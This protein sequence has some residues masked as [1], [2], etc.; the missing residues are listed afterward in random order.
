MY[1]FI[2]ISIGCLLSFSSFAFHPDPNPE[3]SIPSSSFCTSF[4]EIF[5][6]DMTISPVFGGF[7]GGSMS[8]GGA[9]VTGKIHTIRVGHKNTT[10]GKNDA[11]IDSPTDPDKHFKRYKSRLNVQAMISL[12]SAPDVYYGVRLLD[13]NPC[14]LNELGRFNLLQTAYENDLTVKIKVV[15]INAFTAPIDAD[16][17][18]FVMFDFDLKY[19]YILDVEITDPAPIP[20]GPISVSTTGTIAVAA[21]AGLGALVGIGIGNYTFRRRRRLDL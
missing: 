16:D 15:K 2:F 9:F 14:S 19:G 10:I 7:F 21:A 12:D 4:S 6:R 5:D 11:I 18:G 20:P 3:S 1:K 13:E 8:V 17:D